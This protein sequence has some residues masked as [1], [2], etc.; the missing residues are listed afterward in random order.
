MRVTLDALKRFIVR[1]RLAVFQGFGGDLKMAGRRLLATPM[2]AIFAMASLALGVGV[3][4]AAYS[5]VDRVCWSGFDLGIPRPDGLVLVVRA[6]TRSGP[7]LMSAPDFEDLRSA[8]TSFAELA[9]SA[10]I[11]PAVAA[12][13]ATEIQPGGRWTEPISPCST[14]TPS[15]VASSCRETTGRQHP[16]SY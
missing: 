8:Q 12:P 11:Y 1:A 2:F 5:V 10:P 6:D 13:L 16:S 9:A 14:S 3:T 15:S 7:G 4:T